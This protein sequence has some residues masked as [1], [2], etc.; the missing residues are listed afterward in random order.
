MKSGRSAG[1]YQVWVC[2]WPGLPCLF[3]F[4]EQFLCFLLA[5][6]RGE[7]EPAERLFIVPLRTFATDI[8]TS[9]QVL[10]IG[11]SLFRRFEEPFQRFSSVGIKTM[12]TVVIKRTHTDLALYM[13]S[14]CRL[15]EPPDGQRIV[16][17]HPVA[18]RIADSYFMLCPYVPLSGFA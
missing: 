2:S 12:G 10:G 17:L 7:T 5:L 13:P 11:I 3:I 15:A 1:N 9:C 14:L 6:P 4:A 16:L 8:T 18:E